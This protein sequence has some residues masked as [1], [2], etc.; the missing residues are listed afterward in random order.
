MLLTYNDLIGLVR[1]GIINADETN[2]NGASIDITLGDH[3]RCE[4]PSGVQLVDLAEKKAP[5]MQQEEIGD[6]GFYLHPRQFILAH[7]R[8]VFNLPNDLA[9]EFKLKSSLARSGLGH[10]LAGWCDP[11]WHGS[12]LTLELFSS[13]QYHTLILRKGMKIGQMVFFRGKP[14]P[15]DRSYRARG[16]YNGDRGAVSSK[17]V[18]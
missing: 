16:Q 8:E 15:L 3:V 13:L 18:R 2:V 4:I 14:V 1:D 7:S 17:G 9:C 5:T 6:D 10:A 11:D 12:Q